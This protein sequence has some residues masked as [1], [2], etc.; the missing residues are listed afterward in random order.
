[1]EPHEAYARRHEVQILDVREN[2]EWKAGHIEGAVHVPMGQVP[3]RLDAIERDR[4]VVAVCLSGARSQRVADYLSANGFLA[5]NM[6]GGLQQWE[7][8]GLPTTDD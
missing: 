4:P 6:D 8:D 2:D 5:D 1:V 7:S 3:G